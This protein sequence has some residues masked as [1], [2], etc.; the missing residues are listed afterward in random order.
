[1]DCKIF[2]VRDR[3]TFMPV[4]AIQLFP[5][6]EAE[7]YLLSRAGYG[8]EAGD[9]KEYILLLE[10]ERAPYDPFKH[11]TRART[12]PVAHQHIIAEWPNLTNGQVI[13]VRCVLSE[14]TTPALAEALTCPD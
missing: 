4:L 9:H 10:L 5:A 2:E 1:M 14:T 11:D 8:R 7:R 3:G 13:D 12:L 6:N